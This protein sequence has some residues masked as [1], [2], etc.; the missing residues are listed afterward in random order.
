MAES[1]K[2]DLAAGCVPLAGLASA[3]DAHTKLARTEHLSNGTLKQGG[4][5]QKT[6]VKSVVG[7]SDCSV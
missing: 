1:Q 6:C 4:P 3:T 7:R 2:C 5:P